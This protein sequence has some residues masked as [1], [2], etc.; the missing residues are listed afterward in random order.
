MFVGVVVGRIRQW[1]SQHSKCAEKWQLQLVD[2][3]IRN[4]Q[5]WVFDGAVSG[6]IRQWA[7]QHSKCA[8]KWQLQHLHQR[9][10]AAAPPCRLVGAVG[11][12]V[13]D[14]LRALALSEE[15]M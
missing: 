7:S 10:V 15:G 2:V 14:T 11:V 12:W 4:P 13:E 6:Q 8:Q 1:V 3:N 9:C 5:K